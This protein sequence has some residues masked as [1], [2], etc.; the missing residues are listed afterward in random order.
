[1]RKSLGQRLRKRRTPGMT[2]LL[3]YCAGYWGLMAKIRV[4][5]DQQREMERRHPKPAYSRWVNLTLQVEAG[6]GQDDFAVTPPL[7]NRI[8]LLGVKMYIFVPG[9]GN[10]A[11]G[12]TYIRTST[13]PRATAEQVATQWEPVIRNYG[14]PKPGFYWSC[15]QAGYEWEMAQFYDGAGR[16]FGA[17]AE[18]LSPS[19]NFRMWVSLKISEG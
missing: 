9:V 11:S 19:Q 4:A 7:G 3:T 5:R 12:F 10:C 16:R 17:V 15:E 6:A 2:L 18:N 14:G 8:W 1:M 13:D